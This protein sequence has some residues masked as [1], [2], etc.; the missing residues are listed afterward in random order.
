LLPSVLYTGS[1]THSVYSGC[2]AGG[3]LADSRPADDFHAYAYPHSNPDI[4]NPA[5][6]HSTLPEYYP[7]LRGGID[8]QPYS[9]PT[10]NR[11]IARDAITKPLQR[12]LSAKLLVVKSTDRLQAVLD[13]HGHVALQ[14]LYLLHLR[15]QHQ[16]LD[17]LYFFL[18]LLNSRL[19]RE[20]VYV[21]HTAYKWVQP[22]IEQRVLASLP[23]PI[24]KP[25]HQQQIIEMAKSLEHACSSSGPVVEWDEHITSMYE[26]QERTICALYCISM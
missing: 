24:V 10:T 7:V 19:L 6:G 8:I 22:Q 5:N 18:A 11:K 20:Y 14:T 2:P 4:H 16:S 15:K 13:L 23:V 12:Y 1:C 17:Q 26:E 3:H 21:L 25:E 9:A